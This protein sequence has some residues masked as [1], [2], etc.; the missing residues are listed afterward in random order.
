MASISS[1]TCPRS[2]ASAM[3]AAVRTIYSSPIRQSVGIQVEC[4]TVPR[5]ASSGPWSTVGEEPHLASYV[6][7]DV[8]GSRRVPQR[9]RRFRDLSWGRRSGR[10]PPLVRCASARIDTRR[11][12]VKPEFFLSTSA[13]IG[14]YF[15]RGATLQHGLPASALN[16]VRFREVAPFLSTL[17][18]AS[19]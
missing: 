5:I 6:V 18:P 1:T 13:L 14:A 17:A 16:R 9:Q 15:L 19:L 8:P 2:D 7:A 12:R 3:P 10:Q 4:R 11:F